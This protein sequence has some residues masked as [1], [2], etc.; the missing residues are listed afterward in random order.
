LRS[1]PSSCKKMVLKGGAKG[2]DSGVIRISTRRLSAWREGR[3]E[4]R[5]GRREGENE[6]EK[7]EGWEKGEVGR[8]GRWRGRAKVN[9][10]HMVLLC[11]C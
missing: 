4:G 8:K 5:D 10:V 6:G 7:G 3:E 9:L 11:H 1:L 2:R